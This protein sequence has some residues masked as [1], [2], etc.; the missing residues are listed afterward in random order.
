MDRWFHAW[1]PADNYLLYQILQQYSWLQNEHTWEEDAGWHALSLS[2]RSMEG[3]CHIIL[4]SI[5][6]LQ[7]EQ[8]EKNETVV[9]KR[10]LILSTS[11]GAD[12]QRKWRKKPPASFQNLVWCS[13][14]KKGFDLRNR[15][16]YSNW[17][18]TELVNVVCCCSNR[19][20]LFIVLSIPP[21]KW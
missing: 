12:T 14:D 10:R 19:V 3:S 9:A 18:S 11:N 4:T 20:V 15:S 8:V 16:Y 21:C 6:F 13:R 1:W 2:F 5:K 17:L 7:N